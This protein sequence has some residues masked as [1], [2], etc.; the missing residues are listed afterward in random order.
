MS[1]QK[2]IFAR[3]GYMHFYSGP[4]DGDE[5]PKFGGAYNKDRIGHEAYNFKKVKRS[6]YGYVQPYEPPKDSDREVTINLP[7][8]DPGIRTAD[9]IKQALVIF[10]AKAEGY[11]QVVVGWYNSATVYRY[12]QD[13]ENIDERDFYYNI[14]TNINNAILLP[15]KYRKHK[16]PAGKKGAFGRANIVY[17]TDEK[18]EQRNLSDN[19]FKWIANAIDYVKTYEGPNLLTD[20]FNDAENEIANIYDTFQINQTGQGF[21]IDPKLRKE[22]EIYSVN[23]ASSYFKRKGFTVKN[24]GNFKSFDLECIKD[25]NILHVE[26]KGTQ[27][28]GDSVILTSNEVK[29]AKNHITALYILHSIRVKKSGKKFVLSGG[30]EK[31]FNPW[32]ISNRGKLTPLSYSYKLN[33]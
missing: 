23:K 27:T 11:G 14:K 10:V 3:I 28:N 4:Q 15:L 18:G 17:L 16:I 6:L 32:E 20:P 8:I 24:V 29:N 13:P 1:L 21:K 12:Y 7:R 9:S 19:K 26:V 31:I 33:Q 2:V 30:I 25:G 5:K 22:I